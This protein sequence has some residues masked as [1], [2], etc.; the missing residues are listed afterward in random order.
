LPASE[1]LRVLALDVTQAESIAAAIDAAGP[2][3][4][5]VNNAGV[6]HM[7]ALEA[8]P[9]AA[10]RRIFETNTFGVMAMTRAV[11]PQ[12]RA[13]RAGVIVNVTSS[14]VLAPHPLVS[15]YAASKWAIEGFTECLVPELAAFGVRAKLVQ[16]GYAPSTRFTQNADAKIENAIPDAYQ[17]FAQPILAAFADVEVVTTPADVADGVLRA[18]TD[19]SPRLRFPAGSDAEA[20]AAAKAA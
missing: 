1:R 19:A 7:G 20:L 6:G 18:L 11:I 3:D 15:V 8:T 5:L 12:M 10:A 2:I 13:R 16:P 17:A 4:A 9:L 14:V